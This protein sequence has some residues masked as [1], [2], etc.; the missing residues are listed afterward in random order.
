MPDELEFSVIL[1]VCHGGGFLRKSLASLRG[2]D[3]PPDRFEVLVVG[4]DGDS[5]S[6]DAAA[7]EA[8]S[9]ALAISYI[10][11]GST[12]RSARLNAACAAARG[13]F[14]AFADDDC[15]FLPE[16]LRRLSA[17]LHTTGD[18]GIAGGCDEIVHGGSAFAVALDRVF[19]T[20]I[21]SGGIRRGAGVRVGKYYPKLWNMTVPRETALHVALKSEDGLPQVFKESLSVHEDVDLAHRVSGAGKKIVY[22]PEVRIRH[23]R[24][25]TFRS[26]VSRNFAMAR[27]CRSLGIHRFP[28]TVLAVFALSALSL[29]IASLFYQRL[30]VL[31]LGFVG[32]Y[33]IL[34]LAAAVDGLRKTRNL[35][36]SLMIPPLLVS[37][38]FARG[39]G[40]LF[41]L[42]ERGG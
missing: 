14:L 10:A 12:N 42:R 39:L 34:L 32:I 26:F 19:N 41:P 28:H 20:F 3:F 27:T 35:T 18:I 21:G 13:R 30:W 33:T 38:H 29:S 2:L 6:Y 15:V 5:E 11:C 1:P 8:A 4:A 36:A 16:W 17:V 31:L 40:Y 7:G 23:Y 37:L 24:D 9:A 22:A 25:T